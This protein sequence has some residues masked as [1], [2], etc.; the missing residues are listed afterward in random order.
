MQGKHSQNSLGGKMGKKTPAG[1]LSEEKGGQLEVS[2]QQT[3]L[4]VAQLNL[5]S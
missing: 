4:G 5:R 3:R 2:M 1:L